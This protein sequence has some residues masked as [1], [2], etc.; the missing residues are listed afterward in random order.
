MQTKLEVVEAKLD[1]ARWRVVVALSFT[2]DGKK[3]F[4][5]DKVSA[6]DGGHVSNHVFQVTRGAAEV[7]YVG[8]MRKRAPPGRDGFLQLAPG[9]SVRV[10]VRLDAVYALP[11]EGGDFVVR[12]ETANHFSKDDVT[13]VS[14]EARFTLAR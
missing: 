8:M 12:F 9:K 5:L 11:A 3:P 13:L 2:N 7:P 14:N 1:G 6:C 4:D 10:E